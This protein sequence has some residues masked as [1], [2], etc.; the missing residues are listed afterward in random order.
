V[1]VATL[2]L[3]VLALVILAFVLEPVIRARMDRVEIDAAVKP[4]EI[5]DFRELL[6]EDADDEAGKAPAAGELRAP[7]S[8]PEPAE[9]RS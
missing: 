2:L 3:I 4:A 8:N 5:P 9:H 1:I 7:V 6:A